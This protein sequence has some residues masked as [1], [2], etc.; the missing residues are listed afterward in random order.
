MSTS[1]N[2][3]FWDIPPASLS[4]SP[5]WKKASTPHNKSGYR[6]S[7]TSCGRKPD[8]AKL[9]SPNA[10]ECL[11]PLSANM[12]AENGAWTFWNFAQCALRSESLCRNLF[13]G[14][15]MLFRRSRT[16][17]LRSLTGLGNFSWKSASYWSEAP[18]GSTIDPVHWNL[19]AS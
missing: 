8:C 12:R 17:N 7:F 9:T 14:L 16:K 5:L 13:D 10:W 6:N 19:L 11:S 2:I 15:K 3:P 1:Y 4:S 18:S